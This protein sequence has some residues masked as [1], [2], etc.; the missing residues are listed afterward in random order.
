MA[1]AAGERME[2]RL[3]E[4]ERTWAWLARQ[5]GISYDRLWGLKSGRGSY[6][7]GETIALAVALGMDRERLFQGEA[8]VP[9]GFSGRSSGRQPKPVQSIRGVA[10]R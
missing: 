10:Q 8:V 5:T 7:W 9:D 2:Q 3:R 4:T 6:Q 1:K